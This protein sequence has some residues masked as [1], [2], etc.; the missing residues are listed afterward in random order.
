MFFLFSGTRHKDYYKKTS[1]MKK[2]FFS[3]SAHI[4]RKIIDMNLN[5]KKCFFLIYC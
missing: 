1:L 3:Y 5:R 2:H 4:K